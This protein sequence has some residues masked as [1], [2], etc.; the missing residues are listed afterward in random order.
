LAYFLCNR[1]NKFPKQFDIDI[2]ANAVLQ[3]PQ[4]S[5]PAALGTI[6]KFNDEISTSMPFNG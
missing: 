5:G 4:L 1:F 3:W 6:D 2:F